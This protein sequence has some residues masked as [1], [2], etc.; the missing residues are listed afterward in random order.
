VQS[1]CSYTI[2]K[3]CCFRHRLNCLSVKNGSLI[4]AGK[5]FQTAGPDDEKLR[6]P[7]RRVS[8][9]ALVGL[10]AKQSAGDGRGLAQIK[11]CSRRR[12]SLGR[13]H[14]DTYTPAVQA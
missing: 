7:S 10:Y 9:E 3:K 13:C 6:G 2:Q 5:R 4:A 11:Q 8:D 12:G 14:A 1:Q